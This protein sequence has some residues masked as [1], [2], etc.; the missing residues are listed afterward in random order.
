MSQD[1]ERKREQERREREREQ[2]RKE[3]HEKPTAPA[4][5]PPGREDAGLPGDPDVDWDD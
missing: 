2:E 5:E 1:E 4:E 3:H